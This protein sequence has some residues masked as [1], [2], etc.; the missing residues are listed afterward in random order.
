[1][2]RVFERLRRGA[3]HEHFPGCQGRTRQLELAEVV[4]HILSGKLV[5]AVRGRLV[6]ED[7]DC[8]HDFVPPVEGEV[9]DEPGLLGES[10]SE[11]LV[12]VMHERVD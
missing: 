6:V 3:A 11:L 12:D 7:A 9:A 2:V 5:G 4:A 10:G 1:M 8:L